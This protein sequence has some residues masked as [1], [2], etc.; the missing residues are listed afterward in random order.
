MKRV[1]PILAFIMI[2]AGAFAIDANMYI[3]AVGSNGEGI[4][5]TL[6]VH[7][8]PGT[9]QIGI[10]IGNSIVG[11][12]TQESVRY[13]IQAA[14]E[15]ANVDWHKY[16]YLVTIDAKAKEIEGPSAGLPMA[17]LF[18]SIFANKPLP[19]YVSG[20]GEIYPDGTV[21]PV[22]SPQGGHKGIHHTRKG[23]EHDG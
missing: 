22:G 12:D 4:P 19:P 11:Q 7:V 8:V 10:T 20:T 17:L 9:G 21:Y 6:H 1:A 16:D 2:L 3:F 5:A 15:E 14:A 18:Y 13:A 23:R